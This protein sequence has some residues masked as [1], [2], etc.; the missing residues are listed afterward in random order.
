MPTRELEFEDHFD[1]DTLDTRLWIPH[2][3]PQ[4]ST[5]QQSRARYTLGDSCLHLLIEADQ[6]PR[7]P[8]FDGD[9]RVSSLQTGVFA[10]RVGSGVGQHRFNP[11]AV[12][13][14]AQENVRLY[15][16]QYGLIELRAKAIADPRAW[17]RC[18]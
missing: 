9:T 16:P 12:V 2:Y 10:G 17:S 8:E 7:C 4:W 15:T 5:R 18:G 1:G 6:E 11:E 14:Q 13:R 3:L